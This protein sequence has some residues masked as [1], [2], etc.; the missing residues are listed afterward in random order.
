MFFVHNRHSSQIILLIKLKHQFS[1]GSFYMVYCLWYIT[2]VFII[3]W[4]LFPAKAHIKS[5]PHT[6]LT[7]STYCSRCGVR[8]P[9]LLTARFLSVFRFLSM[10]STLRLSSVLL[11]SQSPWALFTGEFS[12][13]PENT[14]RFAVSFLSLCILCALKSSNSMLD[15]LCYL[16]SLLGTGRCVS[17]WNTIVLGAT[18]SLKQF[19]ISIWTLIRFCV[20]H[21]ICP[22]LFGATTWTQ[23]PNTSL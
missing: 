23:S 13:L 2:L 16:C 12:C 8:G 14:L 7:R 19:L 17:H 10:A 11:L 4:V 18:F 22:S 20:S 9:L 21:N 3:K 15:F 6:N 1:Y 5:S